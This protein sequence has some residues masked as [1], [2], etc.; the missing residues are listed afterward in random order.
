MIQSLNNGQYTANKANVNASNIF[1]EIG[2]LNGTIK[3]YRDTYN[4]DNNVLCGYKG[5]STSDAGVIFSPYIMGLFNRATAEADFSP[6]MGV[7]SRYAITSNLLGASR[8]YTKFT[9]SEVDLVI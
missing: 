3:V 2:T 1:A 9:V 7:M 5:P 6:R 8:Y 4:T